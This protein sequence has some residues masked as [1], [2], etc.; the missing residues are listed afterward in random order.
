MAFQEQIEA[1]LQNQRTRFMVALAS[2]LVV[3][4]IGCSYLTYQYLDASRKYREELITTEKNKRELEAA[5]LDVEKL[6]KGTESL[7]HGTIPGLMPFQYNT[8]YEINKGYV[9]RIAFD[10]S[11]SEIGGRDGYQCRVSLF[12]QSDTTV[13]PEMVVVFFDRNGFVVDYLHL[14]NA[15]ESAMKSEA[16]KPNEK[17]TDISRVIEIPDPTQ[18]PAYFILKVK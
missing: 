12:N 10:E 16:L 13:L 2:I 5:K 14:G 15:V 7:L 3:A 11:S 9:R 8:S 17:R 6:R 4:L 18:R 1:A